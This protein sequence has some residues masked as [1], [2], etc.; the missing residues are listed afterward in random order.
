[1]PDWMVTCAVW[2][3]RNAPNLVPLIIAILVSPITASRLVASCPDVF[4]LMLQSFSVFWDVPYEETAPPLLAVFVENVQSLN[5][6]ALV[7][8]EE[9]A[10]P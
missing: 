5:V 1:M 8:V 9:T 3:I 7:L 4:P 2:F 10:P 6:F